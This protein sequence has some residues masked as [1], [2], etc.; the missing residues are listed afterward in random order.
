MWP[1]PPPHVFFVHVDVPAAGP[2]GRHHFL[3]AELDVLSPR[4]PGPTP[5]VTDAEQEV[6]SADR[7]CS[8]LDQG[9]DRLPVSEKNLSKRG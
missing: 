6:G 8:G 3:S 1:P 5:L 7:K 4:K 2:L 9:P